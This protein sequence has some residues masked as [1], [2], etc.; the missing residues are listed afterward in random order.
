M[1]KF[2][3]SDMA[4]QF[5]SPVKQPDIS[6]Y[7]GSRDYF[8][9]EEDPRILKVNVN[10]IKNSPNG[11]YTIALRF[12]ANPFVVEDMNNTDPVFLRN[13]IATR[14]YKLPIIA[15]I[16]QFSYDP[17]ETIKFPPEVAGVKD[18]INELW[19]ARWKEDQV[20]T[21]LTK[22][23]TRRT[24]LKKEQKLVDSPTETYYALVQV[25]EDIQH[26]ER[27][28]KVFVY[29]FGRAIL[30]ILY[31]SQGIELPSKYK[32]A[33]DT[34]TQTAQNAPQSK[35]SAKAK[36]RPYPFDLVNAPIFVV[37]A[38]FKDGTDNMPNYDSSAFIDEGM[39]GDRMPVSFVHPT[40]GHVTMTDTSDIAQLTMY[41]EWLESIDAPDPSD[42][43]YKGRTPEEHKAIEEYLKYQTD[44]DYQFKVNA[45]AEL[46]KANRLKEGRYGS[47][48]GN[49]PTPTFNEGVAP[50][51]PAYHQPA[52][53]Q[54]QVQPAPQPSFQQP[55]AQPTPQPAPQPTFQ[56]PAPQPAPQPQAQSI[57]TDDL[58]F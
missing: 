20:K 21:G 46:E 13:I 25:I 24:R 40:R 57:N 18:E 51:Q 58:P 43:A 16:N 42:F 37:E 7:T 34:Q 23:A 29:Q 38:K 9:K 15:K 6:A 12:L 19:W 31:K 52:Y 3:V 35:F 33:N 10:D 28:G 45:Q 14:E 2:S 41:A 49:Q 8:A 56:Q 54:P 50:Q 30:S 48:F 47:R 27:Q 5:T 11:V 1:A 44:K 55:V 17:T 26:P 36:I 22:D 4:Q 39:E 32:K 53:A